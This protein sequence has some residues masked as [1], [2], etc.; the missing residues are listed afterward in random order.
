LEVTKLIVDPGATLVFEK[1]FL[2]E[3]L[4]VFMVSGGTTSFS[5][6][7]TL[8]GSGVCHKENLV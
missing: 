8:C 2:A 3:V 7:I 1:I 6:V 5:V 4:L